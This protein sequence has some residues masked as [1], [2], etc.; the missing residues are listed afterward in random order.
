MMRL[1]PILLLPLL[2]S[3]AFAADAERGKTLFQRQCAACHQLAQPRNGVGPHLQGIVGH[4]AASVAGFNYSPALKQ[5]GLEWTPETL[6]GFL[7]NPVGKVPG[8]RM[9]TKV[10]AEGDRADIIAFLQQGGA[11]P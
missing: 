8:T 10:P 6:D 7:A 3:P 2:A 9:P 5:A 1:L 11:Q 4:A